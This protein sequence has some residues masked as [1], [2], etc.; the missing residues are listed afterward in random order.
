M[1]TPLIIL[2]IAYLGFISFVLAKA[3]YIITKETGWVQT[4]LCTIFMS[5]ILITIALAIYLFN[6]PTEPVKAPIEID[7]EA[8]HTA[9]TITCSNGSIARFW[10]NSDGFWESGEQC[11]DFPCGCVYSENIE[12]VN[13]VPQALDCP[14]T[15]YCKLNNE[16]HLW[17]AI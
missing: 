2:A 7:I 9:S 14:K 4:A 16:T 13:G 6:L 17:E 8:T 15:T 12:I 5:N 3:E 10:Q 11:S 1:T